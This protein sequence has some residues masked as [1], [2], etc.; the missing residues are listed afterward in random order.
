MNGAPGFLAEARM[1][2]GMVQGEVVELKV[3]ELVDSESQEPGDVSRFDGKGIVMCW[4]EG[5]VVVVK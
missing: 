5:H 4:D 2:F 3:L 1:C